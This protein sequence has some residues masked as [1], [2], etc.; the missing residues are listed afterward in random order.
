MGAVLRSN[1]AVTVGGADGIS[2]AWGTDGTVVAGLGR[3]ATVSLMS[4]RGGDGALTGGEGGGATVSLMVFLGGGVGSLAGGGGTVSLMVVLE[5]GT[6]REEDKGE[7]AW[8]GG[9]NDGEA[10]RLRW[11]EVK[12]M[13]G[14][15]DGRLEEE[16]ALDG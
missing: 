16:D 8:M 13:E 15:A 6:G 12:V 14:P 3:G 2:V 4:V 1:G 11:L 10:T 7:V 5:G 9:G